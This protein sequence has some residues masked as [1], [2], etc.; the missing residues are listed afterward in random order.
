[1]IV[2]MLSLFV[3]NYDEKKQQQQNGP[4]LEITNRENHTNFG[5]E[6]IEA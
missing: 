3:W 2:I 4:D 5:I 1:M 6:N